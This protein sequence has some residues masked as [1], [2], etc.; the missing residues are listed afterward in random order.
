LGSFRTGPL[1]TYS[2]GRMYARFGN[3]LLDREF[4]VAS[5]L[6]DITLSSLKTAGVVPIHG[7]PASELI[8][9]PSARLPAPIARLVVAAKRQMCF[10]PEVESTTLTTPALVK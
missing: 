1:R 8:E 7:P 4:V 9:G 3:A 5:D 2:L 6:V 10:R